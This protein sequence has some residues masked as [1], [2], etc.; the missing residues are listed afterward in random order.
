MFDINTPENRILKSNFEN[1]FEVHLDR[2]LAVI[3][4]PY[5]SGKHTSDSPH[6]SITVNQAPTEGPF[7]CSGESPQGEPDAQG[8]PHRGAF[9]SK[10]VS[11]RS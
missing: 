8:N 2:L 3:Q 7:L 1:V 4:V 5:R 6:N 9:Y 10:G 11:K